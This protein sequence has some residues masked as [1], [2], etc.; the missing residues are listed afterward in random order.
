[1]PRKLHQVTTAQQLQSQEDLSVYAGHCAGLRRL[2]AMDGERGS[3]HV[4]YAI[5]ELQPGGHIEGCVHAFENAIYMLA[6][7]LDVERD[8]VR[9]RLDEDEYL[10]VPTASPCAF[11]N[12]ADEVARWVQVSVPQPK[13]P[14]GWQDSFFTG[15]AQWPSEP[16]A[17]T[18]FSD[19]RARLVGRNDRKMPPGANLHADMQGFSIKR[20]IDREFGSAHLTMFSV[21]FAKGGLCNHHDHPFE[22]AYLVLDGDV[23]IEFDGIKYTLKRG[24]FAWTGVGSR[25]A[26]FPVAGR[27]IRW[28]E[29]QAPQ[30]PSQ[31][32]MRWHSKWERFGQAMRR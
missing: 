13:P 14:G 25:H 2:T 28:L 5:F 10:L 9:F 31:F 30:P 17:P 12:S 27:P 21:E 1:V 16:L 23:D 11:R 4:G 18:N 20:F 15:P 32:G 7:R 3:V 24:D 19:P 29:I 26:F 6:G 22:E 8:G